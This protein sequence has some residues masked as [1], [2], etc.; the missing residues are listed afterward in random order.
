MYSHVKLPYVLYF[1]CLF[2][3]DVDV[4]FCPVAIGPHENISTVFQKS[5]ALFP[6]SNKF[7]RKLTGKFLEVLAKRKTSRALVVLLKAQP[8]RAILVEPDMVLVSPPN[9]SETPFLDKNDLRGEVGGTKAERWRERSIEASLVQ[10]GDVVRVFP[11]AQVSS[12]NRGLRLLIPSSSSP[13]RLLRCVFYRYFNVW[14]E[15][16]V[17][18]NFSGDRNAA[19]RYK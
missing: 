19:E 14:C 9:P 17:D 15:C 8:H 11:G 16:L 5:P 6:F 10:P 12:Y 2:A 4:H 3:E 18:R 1:L 13:T 7:H